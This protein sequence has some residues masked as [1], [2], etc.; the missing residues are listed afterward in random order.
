V[1]HIEELIHG[2]FLKNLAVF[3]IIDNQ[4]FNR[5]FYKEHSPSCKLNHIIFRLC[6]NQ[7][8]ALCILHVIHMAGTRMRK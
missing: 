2:G 4:P 3:I 5:K 1:S 8:E 7:H 6:R